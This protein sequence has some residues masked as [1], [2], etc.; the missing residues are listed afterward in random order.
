MKPDRYQGSPEGRRRLSGFIQKR[1]SRLGLPSWGGLLFGS[2]F[3]AV[4]ALIVLVG[5]KVILVNPASVHAPYWVLTAAGVSF[6]LG[7]LM[8]SGMTWN[9]FAADRRRR[10]AARQYPNEPALADYH[11]HPDGFEVSAWAGAARAVGM[12]IGLTVFLSM[13]N[14]WAFWA[15]GGWIVKAFVVPFDCFAAAMWWRAARQTGSALKFGHSRIAFTR[16]PYS[17]LDPVVIRWQPGDGISQVN[18]GTFTLRCVEEWT[19]ASGTGNT[20]SV[21]VIHEEI[22]SAQWLWDQPRKIPVK[23]AVEL[24][25]DLPADLPPT[26]LSADRPVF[27]ELEVDLDVPGLDF[28]QTYLV[29]I[30]NSKPASRIKPILLNR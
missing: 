20:R 3:V 12:A 24:A 27:W 23:E 19:E 17:L 1:G 25:Y 7:G 22:W 28:K 21:S 13:F 26:R 14:W 5:T 11:W 10:E 8:V 2:L 9:Q 15:D 18:K 29:P 30:Y 6:A 4:G 16:F